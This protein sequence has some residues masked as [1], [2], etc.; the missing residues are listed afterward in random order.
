MVKIEVT[1]VNEIEKAHVIRVLHTFLRGKRVNYT[2]DLACDFKRTE[3]G[4]ELLE[5]LKL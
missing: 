3:T 5:P 1:G 4:F 2:G